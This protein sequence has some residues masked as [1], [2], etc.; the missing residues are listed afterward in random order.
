VKWKLNAYY[1][2]DRHASALAYV[3]D[4]ALDMLAVSLACSPPLSFP[5]YPT[6]DTIKGNIMVPYV[7]IFTLWVA[8]GKTNGS[9]LLDQVAAVIFRIRYALVF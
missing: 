3:C 5:P 1:K 4:D 6:A 9:G 2:R 8:S 7:F